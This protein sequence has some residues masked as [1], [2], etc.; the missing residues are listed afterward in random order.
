MISLDGESISLLLRYVVVI[1]SKPPAVGEAEL[2]TH[3]IC[4][5]RVVFTLWLHRSQ[6]NTADV[7]VDGGWWWWW[8]LLSWL[9]MVPPPQ[10]TRPTSLATQ[11]RT[12]TLLVTAC[13][14]DGVRGLDQ[15]SRLPPC[16]WW[17]W[18]IT[19]SSREDKLG[20]NKRMSETSFWLHLCGAAGPIA[21]Q[22]GHP[23]ANQS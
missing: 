21:E 1:L 8:W 3:L 9:V 20:R 10:L 11:P 18:V 6:D 4:G 17:A 16:P 12:A 22:L 13:D 23:A 15:L 14:D 5:Q 7:Q 19:S 2:V